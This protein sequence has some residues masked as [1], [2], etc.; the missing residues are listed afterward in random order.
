MEV[1]VGKS[2]HLKDDLFLIAKDNSLM[3]NKENGNYRPHYFC[4]PDPT[5]EGIYWAV[6]QSSKIEKFKQLIARKVAK[7][8]KCDTIVIGE[9]G[10]KEN[11]FLIQNMFPITAKYV[12]HEHTINGLSISLHNALALEITEK[13]KRI[14]ELKKRGYNYLFTDV[15]KLYQIMQT[16]LNQEKQKK[17]CK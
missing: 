9:F 1:C 8:G 16:E 13:A 15:D 11:A 3:A 7:F 2:Y 14:L 6:P 4:F 17:P 5:I 12:D 10:G